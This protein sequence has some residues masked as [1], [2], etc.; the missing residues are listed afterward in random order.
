MGWRRR[1]RQV[2]SCYGDGARHRGTRQGGAELASGTP[3]ETSKGPQREMCIASIIFT[4]CEELVLDRLRYGED[5]NLDAIA[6]TLHDLLQMYEEERESLSA[7]IAHSNQ[8]VDVVTYGGPLRSILLY[9]THTCPSCISCG[10][11]GVCFCVALF[12]PIS[13]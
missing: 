13:L 4:A 11:V 10:F 8:K 1:P 6:T 9:L 12:L 2:G 7:S 5:L 3:L